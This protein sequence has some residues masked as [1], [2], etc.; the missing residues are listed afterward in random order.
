MACC[1]FAVLL[2]S[3]LLLPFRA[4]G[5][6]LGWTPRWRPDQG[7]MWRPGVSSA[8]GPRRSWRR[9]TLGVAGVEAVALVL[10]AQGGA[11]ESMPR[12][13]REGTQAAE[14]EAVLHAAVCGSAQGDDNGKPEF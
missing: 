3:Q 13:A 2:L 7:V 12:L 6:F 14:I 1:A 10:L 11:F 4:A 9:L 8:V 5:R